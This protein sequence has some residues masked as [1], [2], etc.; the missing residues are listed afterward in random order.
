MHM[1]TT[2]IVVIGFTSNYEQNLSNLKY[3]VIYT[4]YTS[5]KKR[6]KIQDT[7]TNSTAFASSQSICLWM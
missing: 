7:K 3:A 4:N 6:K 5:I 1:F 2:L